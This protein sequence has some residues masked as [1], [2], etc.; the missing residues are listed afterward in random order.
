MHE[1]LLMSLK[2]KEEFFHLELVKHG[3]EY[4]KAA[5]VARMIVSGKPDELLTDK[6]RQLATEV[7]RKWLRQRQRL[8]LIYGQ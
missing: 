1:R 5:E 4:H 2:E 3:V 6:E 7:C 8:A